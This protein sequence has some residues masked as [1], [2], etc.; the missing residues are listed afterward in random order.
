[1]IKVL[2]VEDDPMVAQFNKQYLGQIDGFEF[3]AIASCFKSAIDILKNNNVNLILL[4]IFMPNINGLKLLEHLRKINKEVDV[5]IVSAA[6]DMHT[7]KKAFQYGVADYLIKPFEFDRFNESLCSY[8]EKQNF[9][10]NNNAVSQKQLDQ[11]ILNKQQPIVNLLPKGIDKNTLKKTWTSI[12]NMN[13]QSFSTEEVAKIIGISRVSMRKYL[14]FLLEK[15]IL[16][17][18][19]EYGTVGRPIYHY[20]CVNSDSSFLDYM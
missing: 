16:S 3:I 9:M 8:R 4:D 1:L 20:R 7:I 12:Q 6:S 15:E 19:I 13:S 2:I 14:V 11:H 18:N 17:I 10:K 5:I